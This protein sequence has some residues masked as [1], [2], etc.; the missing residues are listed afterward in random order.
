AYA[1]P[2]Q[3]ANSLEQQQELVRQ[4]MALTR[5]QIDAMP[6]DQRNQIIALRAQL[7]VPVM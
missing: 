7:G 3:P 6:L 2:P 1:P 5:Q 4:V